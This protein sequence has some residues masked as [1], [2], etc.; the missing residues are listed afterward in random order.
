M[1]NFANILYCYRSKGSVHSSNS[2]EGTMADYLAFPKSRELIAYFRGQ[3]MSVE[4]WKNRKTD[5]VP[6][7]NVPGALVDSIWASNSLTI[8]EKLESK[9]L[10]VVK[11]Y[12]GEGGT[13]YL[14]GHGIGGAYAVLVAL[15]LLEAYEEAK[16]R[17]SAQINVKF[18]AIS[19]GQPRLGNKRFVEYLNQKLTVYRVTNMDDYFPHFPNSNESELSEPMVHHDTEYWI[20]DDCDCTNE[21]SNND[22]LQ[23]YV[24]SQVKNGEENFECNLGTKGLNIRAHYGPYFGTTFRDCS[25][26][27]SKNK[28]FF[29]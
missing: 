9:I 1:S 17:P 8:E 19:F 14:T 28:K 29:P 24:C 18:A 22:E 4:Q 3:E 12:E 27:G 10:K 7:K 6:Y 25:K 13:V 21:G 23:L 15:R 5:L 16:D 20:S 26:S 11:D 2:L